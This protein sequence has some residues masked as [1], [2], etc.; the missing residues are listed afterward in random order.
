MWVLWTRRFMRLAHLLGFGL[1][2]RS[3]AAFSA[4]RRLRTVT[5]VQDEALSY[6]KCD[7]T[8]IL[9]RLAGSW[10]QIVLRSLVETLSFH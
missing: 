9:S 4:K 10:L 8:P 5:E 1:T 6:P 2:Q 7:L 3:D